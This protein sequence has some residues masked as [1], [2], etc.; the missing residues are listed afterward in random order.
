MNMRGDNLVKRRGKTKQFRG[1]IPDNTW[2]NMRMADFSW[3]SEPNIPKN[4]IHPF[5]IKGKWTYPKK[6]FIQWKTESNY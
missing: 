4:L 2:N 6:G 1:P 3:G 5:P